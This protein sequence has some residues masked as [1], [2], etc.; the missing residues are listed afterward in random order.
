MGGHSVE[1]DLQTIHIA[2]GVVGLEDAVGHGA[3][4]ACLRTKPLG[5]ALLRG[6]ERSALIKNAIVSDRDHS[7]FLLCVMIR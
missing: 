5:D 7:G 2:A 1:A 4:P 6:E 3:L